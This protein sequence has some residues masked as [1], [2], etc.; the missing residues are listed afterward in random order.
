MGK[1]V[2]IVNPQN[3]DYLTNSPYFL[4]PAQSR[5]ITYK[6]S[7]DIFHKGFL[8]LDSGDRPEEGSNLLCKYN[9][10]H[11]INYSCRSIAHNTIL[12]RD[13][14]M[15]PTSEGASCSGAGDTESFR[16]INDGGQTKTDSKLIALRTNKHFTYM[17]GDATRSYAQSSGDFTTNR[18]NEVIRQIVFIPDNHFIVFDRVESMDPAFKK[19]WLLHTGPKPK[20]SEGS[21]VICINAAHAESPGKMALQPL[22]SKQRSVELVGGEG[23]EFDVFDENIP[24]RLEDYISEGRALNG[25]WRVQISPTMPTKQNYFLNVLEVGE[26]NDFCSSSIQPAELT[27]ETNTAGSIIKVGDNTYEITF[28]KSGDVGGNFSI[29]N[30]NG[31]L[32]VN[33]PF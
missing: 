25:S 5:P 8:A 12:I 29:K 22:L 3:I 18:A 14:N 23:H 15:I 4:I 1:Y 26:G 30:Q 17:A 20:E 7:F 27:E 10:E 19:Y 16:S 9:N 11:F 21:N 2:W 31:D 13:E 28:N 24:L 33:E 6:I 32:I